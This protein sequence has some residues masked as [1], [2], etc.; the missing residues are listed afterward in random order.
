MDDL[1]TRQLRQLLDTTS[2]A[3]NEI[4]TYLVESKIASERLQQIIATMELSR[5][6]HIRIVQAVEG[7]SS[8]TCIIL[9]ELSEQKIRIADAQDSMNA[10]STTFWS[11]QSYMKEWVRT[12]V[13]HSQHILNMVQKNTEILLSVNSLLGRLETLLTITKID[14]PSLVFEDAFGRKMLLPFQLC[15]SWDVSLALQPFCHP[16]P[17]ITKTQ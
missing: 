2:E 16:Q 13:D 8:N 3:S 14:L 1:H 15:D 5:S 11:L 12:I 7:V 9:E 6:E 10:L 4:R 17:I